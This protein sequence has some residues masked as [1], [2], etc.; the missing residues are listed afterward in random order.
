MRYRQTF[1]IA[2]AVLLAACGADDA[3]YRETSG[4]M[5]RAP[6]GEADYA[7]APSE[8]PKPAGVVARQDPSAPA[9]DAALRGSAS[10]VA[11]AV[12]TGAAGTGTT[13]VPSM[14]IR[15]GEA[16][17]EVRNLDQGITQVRGMVQRLGGYV[18]NTSLTGGR[19]QARS[20]TLELKLPAARF[21][22]ALSA[23]EPIGRVESVNSS[24]E[25]V[26]EEYVDL[27]ARRTNSSRMEQRLVDLLANRTGRLEDVLAV[28]RELA[29]VREEIERFDGR[30]RYL[31]TRAAVSTLTVNL[32][33]PI[34][35]LD[36]G[37]GAN[38]ILRA[39][40]QA[41][42]NFVGFIAGFI[43]LLGVLVPL[44]ALLFALWWIIR[45]LGWKRRPRGDEKTKE[46]SET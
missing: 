41:W 6:Q 9:A 40:R 11:A 16:R 1:P 32:H 4:G 44:T 22:E 31:R 5:A 35:L 21:D 26:G 29:R 37:P 14:L 45:R 46:R 36:D 2:I 23:L 39:I 30:M 19:Q 18:G 43:A 12:D 15:T 25:D 17:V 13:I 24:A 33:E 3:A 27:E 7:A 34:P 28:E 38:P 20:A 42:R 8:A 10:A